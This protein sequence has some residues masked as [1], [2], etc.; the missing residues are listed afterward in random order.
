M[1]RYSKQLALPEFS[2]AHQE[3][4]KNTKLLMVGAGGLGAP[5]LP[6][7]AGAGIGHITIVDHDAVDITNLH[8]Q[9]IYKE[10]DA[11]NNKAEITA[12]YLKN[13][14]S[15]IHVRAI[16]QKFAPA[17]AEGFDLILDGSDNF[18]T[19]SLLNE[20]SI[21]TKT[22]LISA[23]VENF[24]AVAGIFAGHDNSPCYHC[25][26][27]ETPTDACNCNEAG[28]LGT[29]AGLAGLYQAHLTLCFLLG[30]GD[31][32]PGTILS[33]DFKNFRMQSLKLPKNPDCAHCKNKSSYG[34]RR[35]PQ[36]PTISLLHPSNVT[37]HLIVDVRTHEEVANDPIAN[38]LHMPMDTI[39]ARYEEL[40]K[41]KP[42][43]FACASNIRS[44]KVAQCMRP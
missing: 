3:F 23:A 14:N 20:T 5:A 2:S 37:N 8:R 35:M 36:Q 27:P 10:S 7:L 44:M 34:A 31:A 38:A 1:N 19:K 41:D 40:P 30:I 13:L 17:M 4:L 11:G 16:P 43:A 25:L 29:V 32:A 39:P 9:T 28:I 33:F 15:Q 12:A 18:E 26:Y 24:S 22:P 6:Y 21:K 42:L